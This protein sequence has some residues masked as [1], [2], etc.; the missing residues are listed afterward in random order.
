MGKII[1]GKEWMDGKKLQ[2]EETNRLVSQSSEQLGIQ[3]TFLKILNLASDLAVKEKV[4]FGK[5][6]LIRLDDRIP[7]SLPCQTWLDSLTEA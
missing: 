7:N 5:F 4:K 2:G 6:G 1:P 3:A